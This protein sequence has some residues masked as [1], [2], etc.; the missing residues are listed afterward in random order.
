VKYTALASKE[1]QEGAA[2]G[3]ICP[4]CLGAPAQR[5][6][7][8][9]SY[10]V[11]RCASCA[12]EFLEPQ[13]DDHALGEIYVAEY[14][15]GDHDEESDER[16]AALKSATSALYLDRLSTALAGNGKCLL[17]IGCGTG[18]L[19]L[20][21]QSRSFEVNGVEY[22][23]EAATTANRRLGAELVRTGTIENASLP[24]GHFDVVVACDVIEHTRDPKSFLTRAHA[25][26]R[27]GGIVFLVTPS[28][29]SWSRRLLGK[30]WMEYKVE[31]LFYFGQSSLKRLLMDSGFESPVFAGNRKVLSLDYV[32]RHFERFPVP[33]LTPLF[34]LVRRCTPERLAHRHCVVPASGIFV[35]AR[36]P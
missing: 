15:L 19:L 23:T 30:R 14:F 17:E 20:Q 24:A 11:Y 4:I 25:L 29:D 28:L 5:T 13:P 35:T 26:L 6:F 33:A 34:G 18:D 36:K 7:T 27:P 21:A 9:D 3:V 16:V 32:S 2:R 22:S 12:C 1:Q 8:K 10:P 31:H